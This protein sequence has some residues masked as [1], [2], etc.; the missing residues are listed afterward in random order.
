MAIPRGERSKAA[1]NCV[2]ASTLRVFGFLLLGHVAGDDHEATDGWVVDPVLPGAVEPAVVAVDVADPDSDRLVLGARAFDDLLHSLRGQ[3][4]VVGMHDRH[5]AAGRV[6]AHRVPEDAGAGRARVPVPVQLEHRH[7]VRRRFEQRAEASLVVAELRFDLA[8][9]RD[10]GDQGG[11]AFVGPVGRDARRRAP[12]TQMSSPF[13][14]RSLSSACWLSPERARSRCTAASA[15]ASSSMKSKHEAPVIS[16]TVWPSI[17]AMR[18]FTN[19][20]VADASRVQIPSSAVST[21]CR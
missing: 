8:L 10:V 6:V 3:G 18:R 21:I 12:R 5:Q 4:E 7:D 19:V 14:W 1:R 9:G 13:R 16:S 17:S 15:R 11:D 20:V 2:S